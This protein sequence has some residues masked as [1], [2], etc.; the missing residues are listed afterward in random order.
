MIRPP[1]TP[2]AGDPVSAAWYRQ[3]IA[4]VRSNTILPSDSIN[5]VRSA[6]GATLEVRKR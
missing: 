2:S 4:Y 3:L 1:K 5:V 6:K